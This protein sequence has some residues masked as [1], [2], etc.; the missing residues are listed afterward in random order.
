VDDQ[1]QQP[2]GPTR[3]WALWALAIVAALTVAVLIIGYR[4]GITL[5]DWIKLLVV[6]AV[7]GGGAL[8]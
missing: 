1:Q 7:I 8:V 6:P 3:R 4:Y 5:W 2:R